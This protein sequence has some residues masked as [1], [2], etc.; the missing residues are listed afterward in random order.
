MPSA[1]METGA[2]YTVAEVVM[3]VY[4][5]LPN[6]VQEALRE[7][8]HRELRDPRQQARLL[9]EEGL[10]ARGVLPA[11]PAGVGLTEGPLTEAGK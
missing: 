11:E 3:P 8:A 9:V 6:K 10:R 1:F 5:P 7:L 2:S 4:V